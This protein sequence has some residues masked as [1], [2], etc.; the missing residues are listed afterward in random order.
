[1]RWKTIMV[2]WKK[3]SW[4]ADSGKKSSAGGIDR[5]HGEFS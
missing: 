1:M 4:S 5:R 3:I 2:V